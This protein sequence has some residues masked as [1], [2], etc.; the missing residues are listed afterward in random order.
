MTACSCPAA[1]ITPESNETTPE[2]KEND[3]K[4]ELCR[5]FLLE[6][7]I[8]MKVTSPFIAEQGTST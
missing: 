8:G 5:R 3:F 6:F 4:G 1:N 7:R 2:C